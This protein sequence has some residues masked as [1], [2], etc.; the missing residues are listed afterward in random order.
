MVKVEFLF[1]PK[2]EV[3]TPNGDDGVIYSCSIEAPLKKNYYVQI[4]GGSGQ[5]FYE[6]QLTIMTNDSVLEE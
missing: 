6:E 5:W 1:S 2:D 3:T 4:K